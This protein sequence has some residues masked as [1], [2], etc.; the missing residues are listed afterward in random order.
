MTLFYAIAS[1]LVGG[2]SL[3]A[4]AFAWLECRRKDELDRRAK[5]EIERATQHAFTNATQG[6]REAA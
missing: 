3:S 1:T 6:R 5:R 2:V 4:F